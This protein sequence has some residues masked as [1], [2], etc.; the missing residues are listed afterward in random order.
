MKIGI[1]HYSFSGTT[2]RVCEFLKGELGEKGYDVRLVRLQ[3]REEEKRFFSQGAMARRR[4]TPALVSCPSISEFDTVILASP[5]WAFTFTPAVRT[6]LRECGDFGGKPVACFLTCG[7]SVTSGGAL[8]ELERA[9]AAKGGKPVFSTYVAGSRSD[10]GPY[11]RK[12]FSQ[13]FG[14]LQPLP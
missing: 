6:F 11:L 10:R 7:S 1:I 13:L 8:R 2:A 9:I 4:E 14:I 3:L 5:V 12:R